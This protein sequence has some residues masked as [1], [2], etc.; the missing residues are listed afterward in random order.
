MQSRVSTIRQIYLGFLIITFVDTMQSIR[1][2]TFTAID[3]ESAGAARGQTDVPVQ[4]GLASWS[5]EK[6]FFDPW[7]S[8]LYT[9]QPITWGAQKVHGI[10][11]DDL[12]D[13]PEFLS[14]WPYLRDRLEGHVMVA[15]SCGT[16]KKFLRAF[17]GSNFDP[18][19]DTL[20]VSRVCWPESPSHRLGTIV[21]EA[22]LSDELSTL[23]PGKKWHDALYDAAASVMILAHYI[24]QYSLEGHSLDI[25]TYP[26]LSRYRHAKRLR[27]RS[28]DL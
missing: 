22:G 19:V 7:V 24:E 28:A 26:D 16:E 17:P 23:V 3:F 27:S 15:H 8:Y 11:S 5:V 4:I 6:G 12:A 21:D 25:L 20:H 1:D 13:A 18:W 2:L 10:T 14:L 9:E